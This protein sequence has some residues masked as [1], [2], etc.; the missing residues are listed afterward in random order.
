MCKVMIVYSN[1]EYSRVCGLRYLSAFCCT[2]MYYLVYTSI[3]PNEFGTPVVP[4][5]QNFV[6]TD[7][8]ETDKARVINAS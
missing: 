1:A 2:C 8:S 3:I 7:C 5:V 4:L 6:G